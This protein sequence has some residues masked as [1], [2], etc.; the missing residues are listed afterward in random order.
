MDPSKE[1]RQVLLLRQRKQVA[2]P[3]ERLA[4]VVARGREHCRE[5]D[6]RRSAGAHETCRRISEWRRRCR[7]RRERADADD[8]RQCRDTRDDEDR[9]DQRERYVS[10]RIPC[11]PGDDRDDFVAAKC[12]HEQQGTRRQIGNGHS[13]GSGQP[14]PIH[15]PEPGDDE[16]RERQELPQREQVDH[17]AALPDAADIDGGDERD[18][19]RGEHRSWRAGGRARPVETQ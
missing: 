3:R 17:E 12:I 8:L 10:A 9:H 14:R 1:R 13:G 5:G 19:E 4:H 6:H 18:D 2:R 11:F 15:E 16:E 7:E